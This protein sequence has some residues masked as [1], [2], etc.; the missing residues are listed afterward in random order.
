M[1]LFQDSASGWCYLRY[2][3]SKA[4]SSYR[5]PTRLVLLQSEGI[6]MTQLRSQASREDKSEEARPPSWF[7][8]SLLLNKRARIIPAM[9]VITRDRSLR[10]AVPGQ[11]IWLGSIAERASAGGAKT[12]G[13]VPPRSVTRSNPRLFWSRWVHTT[14][15]RAEPLSPLFPALIRVWVARRSRPLSQLPV[16]HGKCRALNTVHVSR[17]IP[18]VHGRIT[19]SVPSDSGTPDV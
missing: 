19:A 15:V 6:W 5:S 4:T 12:M 10:F 9:R 1:K 18:H 8:P 2:C 7:H 16:L 13:F 11:R 14:V 17:I 3:Q